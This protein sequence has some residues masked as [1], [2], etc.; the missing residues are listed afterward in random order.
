[1]QPMTLLMQ[2]DIRWYDLI[3]VETV[4]VWTIAVCY[5]GECVPLVLTMGHWLVAVCY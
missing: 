5:Y 1:M 2:D 4:C 3:A